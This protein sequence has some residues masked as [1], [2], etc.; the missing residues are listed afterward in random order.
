MVGEG[1][2]AFTVPCAHRRR[3]S[4]LRRFAALLFGAMCLGSFAGAAIASAQPSF[5]LLAGSPFATGSGARSL[6][7]SSDGQLLA[8][9]PATVPAAIPVT[10]QPPGSVQIPP[11]STGTPDDVASLPSSSAA[12]IG[13][14]VRVLAR[15]SSG[16]SAAGALAP[17]FV[18]ISNEG[19]ASTAAGTPVVL[20]VR[21]PAGLSY[22]GLTDLERVPGVIGFP[23][24]GSSP[25]GTTWLCRSGTSTV[26]CEY[27]LRRGDGVLPEALPG[28]SASAL[29]LRLRVSRTF[30]PAVRG[31]LLATG[32]SIAAPG[33]TAES[34]TSVSADVVVAR[35]V[36]R[37]QL[38]PDV[39]GSTT[40]MP[41]R[42]GTEQID[43]LNVG[44]GAATPGAGRP[45]VVIRNLLPRSV[46]AG[47]RASGI[48]WSCAG[49]APTCSYSGTVE[50]GSLA[51]R[52][53]FTYTLRS[54]VVAELGLVPGG[55]SHLLQWSFA[56]RARGASPA[57]TASF[58]AQVAIAAPPGSS[59]MPEVIARGGI[60]ELLPGSSTSL[61]VALTNLGAA[62][63]TGRVVLE[64]TM[65]A[66]I[67]IG[68][69]YPRGGSGLAPPWPC[70]AR[71]SAPGLQAF[72]CASSAGVSVAPARSVQL[73][74][75]VRA[76]LHAPAGQGAFVVRARASNSL[77]GAA[78]P[79]A[80]VP[81]I[82]LPGDVG[83][84]A[85]TLSRETKAGGSKLTPATDGAPAALGTGS[86]FVERLDVNDAGGAPIARGSVAVLQQVFGAGV[87]IRAI[88]APSGLRCGTARS[89]APRLSC[90]V[91]FAHALPPAASMPGPTVTVVPTAPTAAGANWPASIRLTGPGAPGAVR[92]PVLVT[93]T[94]AGPRLLP[95]VTTNRVPTAGGAGS[96]RIDVLDTGGAAGATSFHLALRMPPGVAIG[97]IQGA[98]WRCVK[99]RGLAAACTTVSRLA[100]GRQLPRLAFTARFPLRT[101]HKTLTIVAAASIGRASAPRSAVA[102]APVTPRP[103]LH[104][105]IKAPNTVTF[106]DAPLISLSSTPTRS[107]ITLEGDGSG[108]SGAGVTY[109]WMQRC[110]TRADARAAG[111]RCPAVT[112]RVRW[113]AQ[114][115]GTVKPSTADVSFTAPLVSHPVALV[116]QLTVGD[117]SATSSAFVRVLDL[118]TMSARQGFAFNRPHPGRIPV[119]GPATALKSLPR[120]AQRLTGGGARLR[121]A[122]RT[123]L[124]PPR[125]TGLRP[126]G[127]SP[128]PGRAGDATPPLAGAF[129]DLVR[130]AVNGS[131]SI[132]ATFGPVS[133]A[134]RGVKLSGTGCA[135]DTTLSFSNSSVKL[136]SYLEATGLTGE[137]SATGIKLTAGTI[138]APAAWRAPRFTIGSKGLRLPF[139]TGTDVEIDGSVSGDGLA[140]VPLPSG[141]NATTTVT[142]TASADA[143]VVSVSA[144]ATGPPRDTSPDS[145]RP[146]VAI[147]GTVKSDGTFSLDVALMRIVQ[148]QGHS[149]NATGHVARASAD[150]PLTIAVAGTLDSPFDIVAGVRVASLSVAVAP[151]ENSL[152]LTGEGEVVVNA[153]SSSIGIAVRLKYADPRNWSL[154]VTGSGTATWEPLP[155][156]TLTPADISGAIT[157]KDDKY[158][159][160]VN[161]VKSGTWSPTRTVDVANLKLSL[162]N[163]CTDTGA[164]C[165]TDAGVYLRL[166]GDA[167][168]R[169]PSVGAVAANL[170]GT[171]ALPSGAFSVAATLPKPIAVGAGISIDSGRIELSRGMK[172]PA[173]TALLADA[174]E[175][176]G[177]Q[178]RI[179]GAATL[180]V[181]GKI[182]SIEA[183]FSSAGW[184][185]AAQ[186]G[187]FSLPGA[188]GDGATL[189]DTI[190]GW[191]SFPTSLKVV[192]PATKA[193]S[194]IALPANSFKITGSFASPPWLREALKLPGD[195]HAR[196]TGSLD[197]AT[198]DFALRME[199]AFPQ[200]TYLYGDAR[201]ATSLRLA[202]AY[203]EIARRGSDFSIA[204]GG[205]AKL[206][207]AAT[208][209]LPAS[210]ID[211]GVALSF[212][213]STQTIAG[214]LTLSSK[215]GWQ[216]AFGVSGLT[217]QDL[218]LAFQ[219]NLSTLTPGIGF[220][221]RAVLPPSLRAP[222]GIPDGAVTTL[223]ANLS[224]TTPCIGIQI[225]KPS[226]P[227]TNVLDI[228]RKGV[229]TAKQ[230]E[231]EVAPSGCTVGQ[232]RYQPGVSVSFDGTIAGVSV[233]VAA[234][235]GLTPFAIDAKLDIGEFA[236]GGLNVQKTHIEL[237]ASEK[238]LKVQ[239]SGGVSV[240]GTTIE[241]SGGVEQ[242]G[243]TTRIDFRG[244]LTHLS[245]ANAVTINEAL[246]EAHVEIGPRPTLRLTAKGSIDLLGSKVDADF[247]LGVDNGALIRAKAKVVARIIIGGSSG[248]VL[249]GTFNLD[250]EPNKA[251]ALDAD[252]QASV[253]SFRLGKA[254]VSLRPSSLEMSAE[255]DLR[256]V[257]A[258]KVAGAVY[259]G[260][261][262]SGTEIVGPGGK[263]VAAKAG[264]FLL[265]ARDVSLSLGSFRATGT[266]EFGRANGGLWGNVAT[267]IQLLGTGGENSV[268]ISG[269]FS[270]DGNF[271][272]TGKG[273]LNLVGVSAVVNVAA[274]RTGSTFAVHGDTSVSILGSSVS[275]AGDFLY[276]GGT[277][278]V[279]LTG[280][281]NL[282]VGG[283]SLVNGRFFFSNF[284]SDAGLFAEVNI[285][286]GS[287]FRAAG[288][289]T[290]LGNR[291]YLGV[292]ANLDLRVFRVPAEAVFTNCTDPS[293]RT[294]AS[295]TTLNAKAAIQS[296]GFSFGIEV[297]ISS[298]G[299]FRAT[300]RSPVSGEFYARTG[301]IE[302]VAV[303]FYADFRYRMELTVSSDAPYVQL[304]GS[305]EG[306]LYGKSWGYRGWF[307]WGW[308]G[309][310]RILGIRA[311]ISTNPFK[312]CGYANVW[313]VSF[314]GC[315]P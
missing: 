90:T 257:F 202:S 215:A 40:A 261:V 36:A 130:D 218:A 18:V 26:R 198:G 195:L 250:Y 252:V 32:F 35:D 231:F 234:H 147:N 232:F 111:R 29:L 127:R 70:A 291:F 190:L 230:F 196:A 221:A 10:E 253:G 124:R 108:G 242:A 53:S 225:T 276:D 63:T 83:F 7:F 180:P 299:S 227:G 185:V 96:F 248:V 97:A 77:G 260:N 235:V 54:A 297:R 245:L 27:G 148:L 311:S 5:T 6:T 60:D 135:Q 150:G 279:R 160:S 170:R 19:A 123:R 212:S 168:F 182:P 304:Q 94:R 214:E 61:N 152:G 283:Y 37:P 210:D 280:S 207:I 140:F 306:N 9:A 41:G 78:G 115:T 206:A 292:S 300:A 139:G 116:F 141:W 282:S 58:P 236:V 2:W 171:L 191:S 249:D 144:D 114:P 197:T 184:S 277:P 34:D 105:S 15:S 56:I 110:T 222:L 217:L 1:K 106:D 50:V 143:T 224:V 16:S 187:S 73:T 310:E 216:S 169:I 24:E 21:L 203:I 315:T 103:A 146:T 23:T 183:V 158:V 264:D 31:T 119:S 267:R 308:S 298:N 173:G 125:G 295:A 199:L 28:R 293:C 193:V 192:D 142:F 163:E 200:S 102:F 281:G 223:V 186:L 93:V 159:F 117:G 82:V 120:P 99:A 14:S 314:G 151:T 278:R 284:P 131:S 211:L 296:G 229:L 204:L 226:S 101:A 154:T 176:G 238:Q 157:A 45:S 13:A 286:A 213:A 66:G 307:W 75:P 244:H 166:S 51:P 109:R 20:T 309:W 52:L 188:S 87:E 122:R 132:S 313:G 69:A 12:P 167:T 178:L 162:S 262:P 270:S 121:P 72:S 174:S 256:G 301:D 138:E 290:I 17:F 312:V 86:S 137:V 84:P 68:A 44:S 251:F 233:A 181:V 271:S 71:S 205:Q 112:P 243:A 247:D 80:S 239:F 259:F 177:L 89:T 272:F 42:P 287:V 289:L 55:P 100:A 133:L 107:A 136:D 155:G 57:S 274:S 47:W 149:I 64:G 104:A 179:S 128:L 43:L 209:S 153:G 241:L 39:G 67:R 25:P 4:S 113:L 134:L 48:G 201:S 258:A 275:L 175:P 88:R 228:A 49:V 266:V 95:D 254:T 194:E 79:T 268:E 172:Q 285:D 126:T 288:R 98:S 33:N 305:G 220:G 294:A 3:M 265:A 273:N 59:L 65:P 164:P 92:L 246:V 91:R 263:K 255:L 74:L 219:L 46:L 129:C 302:I 237:A 81:L 165:P 145:P 11:G 8:T 269:S 240:L 76:A 161:V 208:E 189:G 38:F 30:R 85:L 156:L 118:P 62:A 22:D 303:A